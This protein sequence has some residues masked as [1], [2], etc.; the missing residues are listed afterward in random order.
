MKPNI[1]IVNAMVRMTCGLS[2]LTFLIMRSKTKEESALHP[3]LVIAAAMKVAE[4]AVRY[5]P[6]TAV[7]NE[8]EENQ[9]F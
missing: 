3:L 5:C 1:G 8:M 6:L 2:M 4:G 9:Q 7:Y